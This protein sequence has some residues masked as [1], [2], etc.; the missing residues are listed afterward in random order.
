MCLI[1]MVVYCISG[2]SNVTTHQFHFHRLKYLHITAWSSPQNYIRHAG[3]FTQCLYDEPDSPISNIFRL[4]E[5]VKR[6]ASSL[7][8]RVT[9]PTSSELVARMRALSSDRFTPA[10]EATSLMSS[11]SLQGGRGRLDGFICL[12]GPEVRCKTSKYQ[13]QL[14][15]KG[16]RYQSE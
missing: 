3:A 14:Y 8:E 11:S 5:S 9:A 1:T 10:M 15:S 16:R 13:K 4:S 6:K 7:Q 2:L 12:A